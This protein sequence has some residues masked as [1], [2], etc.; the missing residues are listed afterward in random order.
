MTSHPIAKI[1][2]GLRVLPSQGNEQQKSLNKEY[3]NL[4]NDTA[5]IE[6]WW[7]ESRW[8][9]TKR[10]YSGK[11]KYMNTHTYMHTNENYGRYI[12]FGSESK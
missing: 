6:R 10:E 2:R 9:Y 5:S 7:N 3:T 11:D 12:L 1:P 8:K 4:Q